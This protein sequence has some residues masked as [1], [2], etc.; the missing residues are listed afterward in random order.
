MTNSI[1]QDNQNDN[2]ISSSIRKFFTRF[3]LSSALKAANAYKSKGIYL[4]FKVCKSYLR[5]SKECNS[6]S[7]DAMSAHVA[8]VFTRYM[9]LSVEN[10]E[11]KMNVL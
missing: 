8:V 10:R 6:L 5:L 2:Q 4:T 11:S 1:T 9:M 7:Y 3:H